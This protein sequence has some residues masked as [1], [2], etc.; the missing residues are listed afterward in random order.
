[1]TK[2]ESIC[3]IGPKV[4][5]CNQEALIFGCFCQRQFQTMRDTELIP[6]FCSGAFGIKYPLVLRPIEGT[7]GKYAYVGLAMLNNQILDC[8]YVNRRV[9]NAKNRNLLIATTYYTHFQLLLEKR[10]RDGLLETI[11]LV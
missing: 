9:W 7:S 10:L 8:R 5:G 3:A 11:D 4:G 2:E 6:T 1:M